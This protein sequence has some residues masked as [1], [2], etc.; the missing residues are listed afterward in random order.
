M[1]LLEESIL[2][3]KEEGLISVR[4]QHRHEKG[5]FANNQARAVL[6]SCSFGDGRVVL[7]AFQKVDSWGEENLGLGE[8]TGK[9]KLIKIQER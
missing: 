6:L 7:P 4:I 9:R 3:E 2:G 5:P 8:N 1:I